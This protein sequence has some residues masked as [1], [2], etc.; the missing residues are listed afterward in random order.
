MLSLKTLPEDD[1]LRII[2][3]QVPPGLVGPVAE[4]VLGMHHLDRSLLSVLISV[5]FHSGYSTAI[6]DLSADPPRHLHVEYINEQRS[7]STAAATPA[8]AARPT[9]GHNG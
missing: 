5:G 4:M 9:S 1:L 3:V 7:A 6:A 8:A 2:S